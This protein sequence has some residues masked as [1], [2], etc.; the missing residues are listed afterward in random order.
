M[1]SPR[2]AW[3][4]LL[5]K[6]WR[7]LMTSRSWWILLALTGPLVGM[8]FI[9]AVNTYAEVSGGAGTGCGAVCDPLIGIWAPT[10]GAYELIAVFLLPF[11]AI[12]LVSGDRQSGALLLELQQPIPAI[13]RMAT[14][15]LVLIAGCLIAGS[16]AL[17]AIL[18]WKMYGGAVNLLEIAVVSLGHLLNAGIT[19]A[20]AMAAASMAEHPSTAAIATLGVTVGTWIVDFVAAIHG[21]FWQRVAD[22]TP[23]ALVDRFQHGLIEVNVT[24]VALTVIVAG[25]V[26]GAVWLRLGTPV[27][28]RALESVAVCGAASIVLLAVIHIRGSADASEARLNS[29]PEPVEAA[30]AGITAPVAIDVHLAPTDPRR[31]ELD[32]VALA[33]LRRVMPGAVIT[34][35]ARSSSGL[36]ESADPGYG[37]IHYRIGD[38]ETIGRAVTEEAVIEAI[39]GLAAVAPSQEQEAEFAGHPLVARAVGAPAV[40]YVAWPAGAALIGFLV[41]TRRSS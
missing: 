41:S 9:S 12:R 38:K 8:S 17:V 27:R 16:A 11:V 28:R 6:E 29:F 13:A 18:L 25:L 32:R 24:L 7:E 2:G 34:Y 10:F 26:W 15:G 31:L 35:T 23:T 40:F 33:K 14:K 30:L 20:I 19:I 3:R 37:E 1:R 4:W 22:V 39:L 21:G 5:R 36:Y